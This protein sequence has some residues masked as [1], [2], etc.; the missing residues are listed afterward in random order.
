MLAFLAG[1]GAGTASPATAGQATTPVASAAKSSAEQLETG[2]P[3]MRS[4]FCSENAVARVC[5]GVPDEAAC[6]ATFDRAWTDC[7]RGVVL[8]EGPS[9]EDAEQGRQT[10]RCLSQAFESQF[11]S[12]PTEACKAAA[13]SAGAH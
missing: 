10:A 6:K 4:F 8:H 12:T 7:T 3:M 11:G 1:C 2:K 5:Y 13:K 9:E